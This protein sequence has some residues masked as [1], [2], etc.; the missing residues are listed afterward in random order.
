M[1]TL[2]FLLELAPNHESGFEQCETRRAA[3]CHRDARAL[4]DFWTERGQALVMGRD[5]PSRRIASLLPNLAILDYRAAK[6]DFRVRLA[7]FALMRRFG[8]DIGQHYL[9]EV[10]PKPAFDDFRTLLMTTR[11]SG[12]PL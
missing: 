3:P 1:Q 11:D 8:R 6:R 4:Y 9:S 10:L 12:V 2:G 7:G 5:L